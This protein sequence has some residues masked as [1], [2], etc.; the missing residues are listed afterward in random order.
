MQA[1]ERLRRFRVIATCIGSLM[2]CYRR[3]CA[4]VNAPGG[5]GFVEAREEFRAA[6]QS[7]RN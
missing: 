4:R 2:T 3:A 5:R 6:S 7:Q 1:F